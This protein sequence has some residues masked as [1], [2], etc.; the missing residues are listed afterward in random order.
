M[1]YVRRDDAG[2]IVSLHREAADPEQ[3]S[4]AADHPDVLA[5]LQAAGPVEASFAQ[6]DA[7]FVRVLEDLIDA[8]VAKHLLNITDLPD[9]AQSK[10]FS[11][12]T[13]RHHAG[14]Q[15]LRLFG[16]EGQGLIPPLEGG[17]PRE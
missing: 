4:L 8:L 14:R 9:E 5:F 10:L 17:P 2:R 12:K 11:R 13:F 6:L 15:A 3:E 1:P 7:S 16:D